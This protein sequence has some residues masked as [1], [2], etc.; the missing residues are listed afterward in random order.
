MK[1]VGLP[2][3]W[4]NLI[5][6]VFSS[7]MMHVL[8]NDEI[9]GAF[10][11]SQGIRQGD[12]L[13]PYLFIL[14]M[15]RLSQIIHREVEEGCGVPFRP[16]RNGSGISH[17]FFADDL[18]FFA[19]AS[20][21]QIQHIMH[22]LGDFGKQSGQLINVGKSL[23]FCSGNVNS[24]LQEEL[25]QI[26]GIEATTDLGIYLRDPIIHGQVKRSTYD[27]ILIKMKKKL[28]KWKSKLLSLAGRVTLA[29]SALTAML[30]YIIQTTFLPR[31]VCDDINKLVRS[32]IW[33]DDDSRK[34]LHVVSWDQICKPRE[35]GGLGIRCV[36]MSKSASLTKLG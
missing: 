30:S 7:T 11:P 12:P 21:T 25:A 27:N 3:L 35:K 31:G 2:P 28:V 1:H 23:L 19:E 13:S 15:E 26:S 24:I 8:W 5:L 9:T 33:D 4:V 34:K 18:M 6:D 16:T 32:F 20:T 17:M 29:K 22:L 10:K 14:C 36:T